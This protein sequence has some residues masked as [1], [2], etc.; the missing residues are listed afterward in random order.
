MMM[1]AAT[2]TPGFMFNGRFSAVIDIEYLREKIAEHLRL[3][4]GEKGAEDS[5]FAA[6]ELAYAT[7]S[8][9]SN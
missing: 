7:I 2:D 6:Y 9:R 4:R 8:Q 3:I 5:A 1:N